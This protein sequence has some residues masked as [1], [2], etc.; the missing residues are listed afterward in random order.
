MKAIVIAPRG[1]MGKVIIAAAQQFPDLEIIASVGP[2]GRDYIGKDTGLISGLGEE[3]GAPV[4]D[5]LESVIGNCDVIIDFSTRELSLAV[6]GAALKHRKALV[7]GTTGLSKEEQKRFKE[8]AG[9]IPVLYA[10]NTSRLVGYMSKILE[11]CAKS[12]GEK[13]DIEIIEMHDRYK[14]DAPSGTSRE[15]GAHMA[16]AMGKNLGDLAVYGRKGAGAR[17][18]GE[19]G[20]HSLRAGSMPS[21]HIVMFGFMGERLEIAHHTYNWESFGRGACEAALY[22]RGKPAGLYTVKDA[23]GQ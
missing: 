23:F 20:Y 1:K 15:M 2:A 10:A 22:L 13:A 14:L 7:C 11:F 18:K 19:I 3:I 5:D 12:F 16:E 17:Q 9:T 21:S 4:V 8:A 6:L